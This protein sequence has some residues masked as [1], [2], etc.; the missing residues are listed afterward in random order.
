VQRIDDESVQLANRGIRDYIAG[1]YATVQSARCYKDFCR[2]YKPLSPSLTSPILLSIH[3]PTILRQKHP[4]TSQWRQVQQILLHV[5]RA[6]CIKG[7]LE[8]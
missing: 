8:R 7:D 3:S 4:Y 1:G 6:I 5:L 2:R